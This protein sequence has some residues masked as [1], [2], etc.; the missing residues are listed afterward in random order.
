MQYRLAANVVPNK[1]YPLYLLVKLYDETGQTEK[2]RAMAREL[3]NKEVKVPSKAIEEIKAEME[4]L[5]HKNASLQNW[6]ELEGSQQ[7]VCTPQTV[8]CL[9]PFV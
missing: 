7:E 8:F 9:H 6:G 5:I 2:A 3:L 4:R 1:F